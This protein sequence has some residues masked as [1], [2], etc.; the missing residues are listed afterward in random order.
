MSEPAI[1]DGGPLQ[2]YLRLLLGAVVSNDSLFCG[3][4][5]SCYLQHNDN[6]LSEKT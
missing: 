4:I 6:E 2:E 5:N 1:D 3:D